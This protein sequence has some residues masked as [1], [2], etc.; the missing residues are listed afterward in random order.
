M[1]LPIDSSISINEAM[2]SEL[3]NSSYHVTS[4]TRYK[5]DSLD[6]MIHQ[7]LEP[8]RQ[9]LR[10]VNLKDLPDKSEHSK[11]FKKY[12]KILADAS[13]IDHVETANRSLSAAGLIGEL[14]VESIEA[15]SRK[16]EWFR[17]ISVAERIGK[18]LAVILKENSALGNVLQIPCVDR[19]SSAYPLVVHLLHSITAEL[20]KEHKKSSEEG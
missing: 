20:A 11:H 3:Y 1:T 19:D 14:G 17:C 16:T 8:I 18:R 5:E 12:R 7:I 9:S 6:V 10:D 15:R 13:G 2:N 4:M